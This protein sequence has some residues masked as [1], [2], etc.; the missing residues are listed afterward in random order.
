VR[1]CEAPADGATNPQLETRAELTW[2]VPLD[3]VDYDRRQEAAGW[4]REAIGATERFGRTVGGSGLVL[5]AVPA[6]TGSAAGDT[7]ALGPADRERVAEWDRDLEVLLAELKESRAAER[8]VALPLPLSATQLMRLA[9]DE[10]EFARELARRCPDRRRS[11]PGAECFH[12]WVESRFG[13]QPLIVDDELPGAADADIEDDTDLEGLRAAFERG[14]W[15]R[16]IPHAIEVPF[17]L[18]LGGRSVRGRIDAV[19]AEPDGG[20]TV[21][22]WKTN[23]TQSADPLQLAIYRLAW[24]ELHALPLSA[25]RAAFVY[26]RTGQTVAPEPLADRDE[27]RHCSRRH[28]LNHSPVSFVSPSKGAFVRLRLPRRRADAD[29]EPMPQPRRDG[30]VGDSAGEVCRTGGPCTGRVSPLPS[31]APTRCSGLAVV[32]DR[33]DRGVHAASRAAM[34]VLGRARDD[35]LF[36][37]GGTHLGRPAVSV[38]GRA[39]V[40][41]AFAG[42]APARSRPR[43]PGSRHR[44]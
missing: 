7:A 23:R 11:P 5:P 27:L 18:V 13:Q 44:R 31:C 24:A 20:F 3:P 22:D 6:V 26:I 43:I 37:D 40:G 9:A 35:L 34:A 12:A 30:D 36:V 14:E 10:D 42:S 41:C 4:V 38:V 2:P 17:H 16:R 8:T 25:V 28:G 19:Y 1:W 39:P 32:T 21:I 15:A 33:G 29:A